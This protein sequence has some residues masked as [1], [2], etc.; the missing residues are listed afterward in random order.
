MT[1]PTEILSLLFMRK[2]T[3]LFLALLSALMLGAATYGFIVLFRT[4]SNPIVHNNTYRAVPM[5]V[6][7]IQHFGRFETLAA[8]VLLPEGYLSNVFMPGR[9][10]SAF[11]AGL[12]SFLPD[13]YPVIEKAE[14][15]CSLHPSEKNT[16]DL[17]FC[18]SVAEVTDRK[19]WE[20]FLDVTGMEYDTREY[21]AETIYRLHQKEGKQVLYVALSQGV[22]I[23]SRS[24]MVLE[25]SLRHID[26]KSS[27]MENKAFAR[28]VEQT[29]VSKPMRIFISHDKIPSLV[30]AYLGAPLQKYAGFLKTTG[31]WTVL[32]GFISSSQ[33][34]ADGYTWLHPGG[35]HFFSVFR[36]QQPQKWMAQE[37]LPATTLAGCSIGI[38]DMPLFQERM[39]TYRE[40]RKS[41]RIKPDSEKTAW[42]D[43]LYPT[44]VS[45]ACIPFKGTY[46]WVSIIHSRYI[47]QAKIQFALLNKQEENKV[48][49]NPLPNMLSDIFGA[50]FDVCPATHYCYQ[51]S[52]ILMGDRDLLT[53]LTRRNR[54]GNT[55]T[56]SAAIQQTKAYKG[57]MNTASLTL[58]LH[59]SAGPEPLLP[60]L[61]KRYVKHMESARR[62]NAQFAFLQFSSLE[63]RMYAH[64]SVYGDSLEISP[65]IPR[66]RDIR[67]RSAPKQDTLHRAQPPYSLL[68]HYTGKENELFQSPWPECRLILRDHLGKVLWEKTMEGPIQ[69]KVVQIDFLKN[70]KL[71]MLF[72]IGNRLYL[73]DRLGRNV[74]P[75]PKAYATSIVYGPY[76]F[77]VTGNKDYLILLVHQDNKLG[78]YNKQGLLLDGWETLIL[79]GFLTAEPRY[80]SGGRE[81][82]WV[83]YTDSQ[84]LV[85]SATGQVC[86]V[87]AQKDCLDPRADLKISDG[88]ALYGTT[89]EGKPITLLLR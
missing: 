51:G 11:W 63:D 72:A 36:D 28:L 88:Y 61:D 20:E 87:T 65:L 7:M 9:E 77:D 70:N 67:L 21:N 54:L 43:L 76:V 81:G 73:M 32:D 14:A 82:Y 89:I 6:V 15:L 45:L 52:Y 31:Q 35:E 58:F 71:Q 69:D 50:L 38:S 55:H 12:A 48:M 83:V 62:Y 13:R 84:T 74:A 41:N 42:F 80:V 46:H 37:I 4:P 30:A 22:L 34:Q 75:Y 19:W 39:S 86:T 40:F 26:R 8:E 60:L 53:D 3:V 57:T 29:P 66:R 16:L 49:E 2:R 25:S 47:Q 5:D 59:L 17:L 56:L 78:C 1:L 23:A 85:L 27:I 18:L 64:L 68:N 33:L 10:M 79:P 44:E 24:R